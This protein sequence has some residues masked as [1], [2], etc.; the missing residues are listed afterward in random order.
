MLRDHE[1]NKLNNF[2]MGW[3]ADDT[4][5]C[6]ELIEW[7]QKD[8]ENVKSSGVFSSGQNTNIKHSVDSSFRPDTLSWLLYGD[9]IKQCS[10]RYQEK[11]N[12]SGSMEC[13]VAEGF[14]VQW[15]PVG[16][17]YKIWHYERCS[18]EYPISTRQLVFMTYLNDLDDGGTE[19][20]Y[21]NLRIKAE[22]GLTLFW[23]ADWTFTHRSQVSHNKEK[24]IA[25]GW[26]NIV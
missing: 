1:V 26:L 17:G 11:Y 7:H 19:F 23:P 13:K 24:Y 6:D 16:G 5:F 10:V 8:P 12:Y 2:L 22:K 14:N 21:Q 15:Y 9:V 25:T 20:F 4:S 18:A 3:Y